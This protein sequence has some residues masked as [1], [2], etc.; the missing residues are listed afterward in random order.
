MPLRLATCGSNGGDVEMIP[1]LKLLA[2]RHP[3]V[4]FVLIGRNSG[5]EPARVGLPANV[6]NPWISW[7]PKIR[8]EM[9]AASLNHPV[10]SVDE[11]LRLAEIF[12]RYTRDA[13]VLLD[14]IVMWLGQHGTTHTPLPSIKDRSV[15]TKP[16]DSLSLYGGYLLRGVN[17]WRD[18][19][20]YGREEV[21]L[22]AD[23]RNVPKYRDGRYP[24]KYPVLSQYNQVNSIKHEEGDQVISSTVYGFYSRLEISGLLPGTPFADLITYS[25]DYFTRQHDFGIVFNETRR[26]VTIEKSRRH[27]LEKWVYPLSPGFIAGKWSEATQRQLGVR[28]DP[29]PVTRYFDL[30]QTARCTLTTPSSGSGWATAKPWE[31]FAAGVVCFFHPAY[32]D[33]NHILGDAPHLLQNWLRVTSPLELRDRVR[34]MSEH[35][36]F[37][38]TIVHLQRKHYETAI[39]ELLYLHRIEERLG[40]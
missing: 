4:E 10:L 33:Q 36:A 17:A 34:Y 23:P 12:D 35:P 22:N 25:G 38:Q 14:G 8:A 28:I 26:D 29:V 5:E 7:W 3:D 21:L 11:H 9:N 31:C 1:T 19:D 30:L 15:L 32:D 2:E 18:V 37:W 6:T 24:W 27:I 20:P 39:S 16:Y 40:L 13:F